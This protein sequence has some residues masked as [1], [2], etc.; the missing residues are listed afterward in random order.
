MNKIKL[1]I[2][3]PLIFIF[4]L[5]IFGQVED[6]FPLHEGD[7][8][9][10][11]YQNASGDEIQKFEVVAVDSL[12]DSSVVYSYGRVTEKI[13]YYRYFKVFNY[14]KSTVYEALDD[15]NSKYTPYL[16]FNPKE[17]ET[18]M[19]RRACWVGL[20]S[21][22]IAQIW[23][24]YPWVHVDSVYQFFTAGDSLLGFVYN[25]TYYMK[26]LGLVQE[27]LEGGDRLTLLGCII[28]GVT[29]GYLTGIEDEISPLDYKLTI[30]NYPNPFNNQ[31][32][33]KYTIPE[34]E[35]VNITMY[36]M[37]GREIEVLK[38][39]YQNAGASTIPW[40]AKGLSSGVYFAVIKYKNQMLTHKIMYQK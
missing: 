1:N 6:Y 21:K 25:E 29:Y 39:E 28:N 40:N 17:G 24:Y 9:E 31:T 12:K 27:K 16:K 15:I 34:A 33:I 14:E 20:N 32:I 4:N 11:L 3:I 36:D 18:W 7:Y 22:Y 30:Q 13:I 26:G 35:F 37:L 38:N 23:Q 19:R 8:W 2:I 10:Y 5:L